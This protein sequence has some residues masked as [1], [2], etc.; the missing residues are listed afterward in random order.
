VDLARRRGGTIATELLGAVVVALVVT[1][2]GEQ[3]IHVF[4]GLEPHIL[5]AGVLGAFGGLAVVA[6][7]RLRRRGWI[8][9]VC[10][11][12]GATIWGV[13][14]VINLAVRG[15]LD[16]HL[17]LIAAAVGLGLVCGALA[18]PIPDSLWLARRSAALD[19]NRQART[20]IGAWTL[21]TGTLLGITAV[22]FSPLPTFIVW[23][24]QLLLAI[25]FLGD[26]REQR[27]IARIRDGR[28]PGWLLAPLATDDERLP[29]L[30]SGTS[31]RVL[32][33]QV[34]SDGPVYRDAPFQRRI[35]RLS[36]EPM[37]RAILRRTQLLI[38]AAASSG[39][40]LAIRF[41]R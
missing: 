15:N 28:S 14:I 36:S 10:P 37:P 18:A 31:D 20:L 26:F 38:A 30:W 21:V 39:L 27:W 24:G 22:M 19:G 33:E 29:A 11:A 7:A 2:L 35:A 13:S 6:M 25:G 40:M 12:G 9:I 23:L 1:S 8:W 3:I 34:A 5:H 4:G 41:R 32:I 16:G 17:D